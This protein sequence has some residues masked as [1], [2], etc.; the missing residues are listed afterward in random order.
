[1]ATIIDTPD[2]FLPYRTEFICVSP[3]H[4][5]LSAFGNAFSAAKMRINSD[6]QLNSKIGIRLLISEFVQ[7]PE[8]LLHAANIGRPNWSSIIDAIIA[9]KTH[10][11][12]IGAFFVRY[13]F[14]IIIALP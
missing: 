14:L 5:A 4:T 8:G 9:E 7:R 6:I 2:Y 1:M 12:T 10:G 11:K 3:S 13:R